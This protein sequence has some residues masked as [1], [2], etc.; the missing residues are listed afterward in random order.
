MA[1]YRERF[2]VASQLCGFCLRICCGSGMFLRLGGYWEELTAVGYE[3]RISYVHG[4]DNACV[5]VLVCLCLGLS[6]PVSMSVS[7]VAFDPPAS[8]L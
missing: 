8:S 2:I 5:G 6:A 4:G 3:D 7:W 1:S